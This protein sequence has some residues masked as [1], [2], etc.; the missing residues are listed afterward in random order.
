M[1]IGLA[2]T[3]QWQW[4]GMMTAIRCTNLQPAVS[5][6]FAKGTGF[7]RRWDFQIG[8]DPRWCWESQCHLHLQIH[9]QMPS[10]ALKVGR[11]AMVRFFRVDSWKKNASLSISETQLQTN[12]QATWTSSNIARQVSFLLLGPSI[13]QTYIVDGQVTVSFSSPPAFLASVRRPKP[14]GASALTSAV[15]AERKGFLERRFRQYQESR[16]HCAPIC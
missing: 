12:A 13:F 8:D 7:F 4:T 2:V 5:I 9:P 14:M 10:A 1:S 15:S 3:G 11:V 16:R 6:T